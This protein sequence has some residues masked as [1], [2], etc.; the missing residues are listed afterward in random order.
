MAFPEYDFE[1]F[2]LPQLQL[3]MEKGQAL[4]IWDDD[5]WGGKVINKM[6]I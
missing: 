3:Q 6:K 1:G 5:G 4:S 2:I